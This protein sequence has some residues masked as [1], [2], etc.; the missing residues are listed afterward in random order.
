M[1]NNEK[2]KQLMADNGLTQPMVVKLLSSE[3][4][5]ISIGAVKSWTCKPGTVFHQNLPGPML[6]L[7]ELKLKKYP[8]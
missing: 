8:T 1:T 2:L 4:G 3:Y 7:L 5:S 6:E